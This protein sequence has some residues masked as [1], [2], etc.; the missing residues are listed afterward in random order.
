M[1]IV[2]FFDYNCPHCI[3]SQPEFEKLV[4]TDYGIRLVNNDWPIFG[5]GSIAAARTAL[6]ATWQGQYEAVHHALLEDPFRKASAGQIHSIAE[7]AGA[8]PVRLDV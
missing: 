1:T 4:A 5:A 3:R 2:E 7:K 8:D 6:A